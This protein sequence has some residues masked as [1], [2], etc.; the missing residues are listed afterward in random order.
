MQGEIDRLKKEN[1]RLNQENERLKMNVATLQEEKKENELT[2][3]ELMKENAELKMKTIDLSMYE[4]WDHKQILLWILSI[5]DGNGNKVFM[6]YENVLRKEL[7]N[8][9]LSGSDLVNLNK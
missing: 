5:E 1:E 3:M 2:I 8:Q 6:R 9:E 4:T 7:E